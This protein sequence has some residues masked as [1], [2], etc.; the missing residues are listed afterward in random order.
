VAI[1]E[2]DGDAVRSEVGQVVEWVGHKARLTLFAVGDHRGASC[3]E[4]LDGVP[5]GPL[6]KGI[7]ARLRNPSGVELC[8]AFQKLAR[9]RDTPDRFSWNRCVR[10]RSSLPEPAGLSKI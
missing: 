6:V 1:R 5:D 4:L 2:G 3:L 7:E 8:D 9:P 10:H